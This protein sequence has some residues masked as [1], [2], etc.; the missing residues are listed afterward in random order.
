MGTKDRIPS[1]PDKRR[2]YEAAKK[3]LADTEADQ[4]KAKVRNEEDRKRRER[5]AEEGAAHEKARKDAIK[6]DR[7]KRQKEREAAREKLLKTPLS[8]EE[9]KTLAKYEAQAAAHGNSNPN[10]EMMK[11]LADLRIRAKLDKKK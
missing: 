9:R 8:A 11:E 1:D 5:E 2:E 10:P 3:A 4:E 6:A 7:E